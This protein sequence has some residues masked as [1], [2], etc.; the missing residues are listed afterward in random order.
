MLQRDRHHAPVAARTGGMAI[1]VLV[2]VLLPPGGAVPVPLPES[3]PEMPAERLQLLEKTLEERQNEHEK[4]QRQVQTLSDEL[5]SVKSSLVKAAAAVQGQEEILTQLEQQLASLEQRQGELRETLNRRGAQKIKVLMV[6][7]RLAWRP[8]EALIVQPM[9]PTATVRSA[10]LLRATM[11]QILASAEEIKTEIAVLGT[12]QGTI[13]TKRDRIA[14][15]ARELGSQQYHLRTL[16]ERKIALQHR[17]EDR[18][19][20]IARR[21]HEISR[22]ASDLRELIAGIE[23]ERKQRLAEERKAEEEHWR[24]E[25]IRKA[26]AIARQSRRAEEERARGK[27]QGP[28][29]E[30]AEGKGGGRGS[31]PD[32]KADGKPEEPEEQEKE[33]QA[34]GGKDGKEGEPSAAHAVPLRSF[35]EARGQLPMPARGQV[36]TAYG[37]INDVGLASKGITIHARVDAQV[38][39]PYDGIVAFSGPF[40]GYGRLL[41]I[42]HGEGYHTVLAGM[43]RI[44]TEVG[45]HL[46]AGEPVG[47]IESPAEP[48]L[49][50][51]LRREGQPINPLPWLVAQKGNTRG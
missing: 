11:P 3:R 9:T 28:A 33:Y 21:V 6:L 29:T 38:I 47:V 26:M 36:T 13:S 35:S 2:G 42:E 1:L 18:S 43:T 50:V 15:L 12:L 48:V 25:E 4:L 37:Q 7:Q 32:G 46:L 31:A 24:R 34:Y 39:A 44:D 20:D 40:R 10:I 49:Y 51:E 16:F 22:E 23:E 17:A 41:I 27:T 8:V 14:R 30:M 5:T 45:Q 19:R